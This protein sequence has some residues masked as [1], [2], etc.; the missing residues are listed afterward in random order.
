MPIVFDKTYH[1][2][3]IECCI[4][5]VLDGKRDIMMLSSCNSEDL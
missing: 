3:C 4:E 1:L 2:N 5:A